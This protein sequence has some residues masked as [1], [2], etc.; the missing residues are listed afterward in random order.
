MIS[1]IKSAVRLLPI[2][3]LISSCLSDSKNP[4]DELGVKSEPVLSGV[5][6]AM[7]D[8]NPTFE[9]KKDSIHYLEDGLTYHYRYHNDTIVISY[10]DY[11]YTGAVIASENSLCMISNLDTAVFKRVFK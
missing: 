9:F 2:L 5:W 10:L 11:S 6:Q 4:N 8:P 3:F 7:D 1:R